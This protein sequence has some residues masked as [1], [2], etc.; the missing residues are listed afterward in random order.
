M[1]IA[2]Q[3]ELFGINAV[4]NMKT[5]STPKELARVLFSGKV[6]DYIYLCAHATDE[7]F[8]TKDGGF[9]VSWGELAMLICESGCTKED[10]VFMLACCRSGYDQVA[11]N[12]FYTCRKIQYVFGPRSTVDGP[13]LVAGTHS[14]FYN[15][16]HRHEQPDKA[17]KRASKSTGYDF[18]CYDMMEAKTSQEYYSYVAGAEEDEN[19]QS[20]EWHA[21]YEVK[22]HLRDIPN[23]PYA[24]EEDILAEASRV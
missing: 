8:G 9:F 5:V 21:A 6:Y 16:V 13:T 22:F 1:T 4:S 7:G 23:G 2:H 19:W 12:L 11:F 18:L 20:P 10:A 14:F 17:A 15:M 3:A 24:N